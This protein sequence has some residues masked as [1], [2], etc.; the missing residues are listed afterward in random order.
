VE[1]FT[2]V[3]EAQVYVDT[4]ASDLQ[5]P[6]APTNLLAGGSS[7]SPWQKDPLFIISWTNPTDRSGIA[8]ILYKIGGIP[9][10]N[11]DTTNSF[12]G[13]P[14]ATIHA[15]QEN[16]QFLY[17]WLLDGRGNVN[18]QNFARVI[19]RYDKT[20]PW[21]KSID[22]LN[23]GVSP[24]WF[25]Q[26][27]T[28]LARIRISYDEMNPQHLEL[29]V[30]S[31]DKVESELQLGGLNQQF[32][33]DLSLSNYSDGTHLLSA[34]ISDGAG[35]IGVLD[36][37]ALNLDS[38]PPLIIHVPDTIANEN[39]EKVIS[40]IIKDDMNNIFGSLHYKQ[41]G[42]ETFNQI[43]LLKVNDST[44]QS[45]VPSSSI[46]S[47][48][49]EYYLSASDGLSTS[50]DPTNEWKTSPHSI[51]VNVIGF[52]G[53]GLTRVAPQPSGST[54]D[55]FRMISV[56]MILDKPDPKAVLED[57]L[58]PYDPQKWRLFY[59]NSSKEDYDEFP[60]IID[61]SPGKAFWLIVKEP[62]RI[63]DSGIGK[64]VST[65]RNYQISLKRGW[66]DIANP[67]NFP[68]NWGDIILNSENSRDI[69]GPYTYE[70]FWLIPFEVQDIS[71][72]NGY[73]V[74]SEKDD[75]VLEIPPVQSA[76]A[77]DKHNK[78]GSL[79]FDWL[80]KI[81]AHC[82]N[83]SDRSNY[84]GTYDQASLEWDVQDYLE[85]PIVGSFVSLYFPHN[86]WK[87]FS[88]HFTT[89]FRPKNNKG[90]VW[91]FEVDSNIKDSELK[92][93]FQKSN[94]FPDST[95]AF[96]Y[97]LTS[98]KK[99]DLRKT[100]FYS[101]KNM[102]NIPR[103]FKLVMG[104]YNYIE[105]VEDAVDLKPRSFY[106]AQNY[107]NPFNILTEIE[108]QIP[109]KSFV[110]INIYN[111]IGQRIVTLESREKDSGYYKVIW[112]GLDKNGLEVGT[113]VYLIQMKTDEFIATKKMLL[114]K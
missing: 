69:I 38:T 6:L 104:S 39:E 40:V 114:I 30:D 106:L 13:D 9:A 98:S 71:P 63:I 89:D 26:D 31:I 1:P 85:P 72:W 24:N 55:G 27:S 25:N 103:P 4:L 66:N 95:P 5:A 43:Q 47:R 33:L 53:E 22:F 48:G 59:F 113:G 46:S 84:I 96:V 67:F 2:G 58:G 49:L 73:S 57:D 15:T 99:I 92:L 52:G 74:Y 37:I 50:F 61:F 8:K 102:P 54:Q 29:R 56:P 97:D 18:Y 32:D 111:S 19:L 60:N 81:E 112:N 20:A 23:P 65:G 77:N 41:G 35:N 45:I 12:S 3:A 93:T 83:S 105:G 64:S 10:A 75:I 108:Y 101:Y 82:Q 14:P 28:L 42:K 78:D 80:L 7:P 17:L 70:G 36:S 76:S 94:T 21:V 88:G 44:Y 91:D 109:H 79:K 11:Y 34:S 51:Q 90:N 16:G 100:D 86:N 87:K 107:P 62:N 68:V 110:S